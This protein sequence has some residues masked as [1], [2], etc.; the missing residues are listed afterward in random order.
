MFK[1][2]VEVIYCIIHKHVC[3]DYVSLVKYANI[4]PFDKFFE[5]TYY[6]KINCI[7]ISEVLMNIVSCH[8]FAIDN[9]PTLILTC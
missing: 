9:K 3:I 6:N 5:D 8:G 2:L 7:G 4:L 1:V